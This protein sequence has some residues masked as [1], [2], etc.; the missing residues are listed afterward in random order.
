MC[1]I[2]LIHE[3]SPIN[4]WTCF[5][6][7]FELEKKRNAKAWVRK[8]NNEEGLKIKKIEESKTKNGEKTE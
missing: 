6:L 4:K 2:I 3:Q 5:V 8:R 7:F 1:N